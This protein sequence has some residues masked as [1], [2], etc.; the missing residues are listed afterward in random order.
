MFCYVLKS[1]YNIYFK[2]SKKI[3]SVQCLNRIYAPNISSITKKVQALNYNNKIDWLLTFNIAYFKKFDDIQRLNSIYA[4]NIAI[5]I[6][7][8]QASNSNDKRAYWLILST[9]LGTIKNK[10]IILY[11]GLIYKFY[12][13][14][15]MRGYFA[16]LSA[17]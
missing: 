2:H 7:Q 6:N 10:F 12:I 1:L 8:V 11:Y 4:T 16:V 17:K 14:S 9:K 3:D 5:I 15:A 13:G